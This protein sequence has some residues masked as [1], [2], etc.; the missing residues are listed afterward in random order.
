D[1]CPVGALTTEDF[2]FKARPWELTN[3][4]SLDIYDCVGSN[5]VLGT[6]SNDIKRIMPRANEWVNE[7]W[8]SDKTRFGHHF[9]R[10]ADRL[11][12]PLIKEDGA[13]REATWSEALRVVADGLARVLAEHG[14]G[15]IGG[16]GGDRA[17]NEDLYLFA[18]FMRE[19][20]GTNNLDFRLHWPTNT[21]IEEAIRKV[22]L[23]SGSNL[24]Q[25]D[26]DAVILTFGA[27]L[28]EEQ[29]VLYLRARR[30]AR[31]GARLYVVQSRGTK[32]MGDAT[33]ALQI[34]PGSAAHLAA[35][36]LKAALDQEEVDFGKLGGVEELRTAVDALDRDGLLR[37]TGLER[38]TVD[39]LAE[40]IAGAG[41]L[42]IMVGREAVMNA[43]ENARA[44]VDALVALLAATGKARAENSGLV[45]LWPHNNS[46]GAADMGVLPHLAAGYEAVDSPGATMDEMLG[47]I[48]GLRA[49]YI[50][51]SN[52]AAEWPASGEVLSN[53]DFLVVQELFMTQ[54]AELADVLL[55]AASFAERDGSFTNFERRVQ[56]YLKGVEPI[57]EALP[58]WQIIA[59]LA[60]QFD[61]GWPDYFVAHDVAA[62]IAKKVKPYKGFT[63]DKLR[64]EP[65]SWSTT[66]AG[67]HIYAGTSV[68]NT[69][70]GQQWSV[71]A[72]ARRPKYDLT[73]HDL[74]PLTETG[75]GQLRLI[76]QRKL[77]DDGTMIR[78]S[79]LL[80][81][82]RARPSTR[83]NPLDAGSLQAVNGDMITVTTSDGEVTVPLQVDVKVLPGTVVVPVGVAGV[84]LK[85]L[86]AQGDATATVTKAI[87]EFA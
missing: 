45:A 87:A 49:A 23:S 26:A 58:D 59:R 44:L 68:L 66:A 75:E 50:M 51:A 2:R 16:I 39:A 13:F 41:S 40:A 72:E 82:R 62:E 4:P 8:I 46:Q 69:W 48:A 31:Q 17:G 6:R 73:W 55:P 65:V 14:A 35:A 83:L 67:H 84:P 53:L 61:A 79:E 20:I 28:Q 9:I 85:A 52:P 71:E 33:G 22:G 80:D 38:A 57:G 78:R 60:A 10:A 27:D 70:H 42:L 30:A 47:G 63:Y 1:V 15:A 25:L 11:T 43:G 37:A 21:G 81:L 64:G 86:G 54:T 56:R 34:P 7:I 74:R 32:E 29:P 12:V 18:R 5:I 77:Y 24:G 36:L 3:V 19:V 76:Q